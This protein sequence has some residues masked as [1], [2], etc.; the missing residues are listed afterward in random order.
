[1]PGAGGGLGAGV[2][3]GVSCIVRQGALPPTVG[4]GVRKAWVATFVISSFVI[5]HSL[6]HAIRGRPGLGQVFTG[7]R[8]GLPF[9]FRFGRLREVGCF[10]SEQ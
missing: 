4:I 9:R 1:M 10:G 5:A 7:D 6:R 8:L 2:L 3:F